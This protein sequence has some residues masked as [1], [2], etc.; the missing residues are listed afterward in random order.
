MVEQAFNY[1]SRLKSSFISK[2]SIKTTINSEKLIIKNNNFGNVFKEKDP[3][4]IIGLKKYLKTPFS[5]KD[6]ST[7]ENIENLN[8]WMENI[9][10]SSERQK[11]SFSKEE[12]QV[13]AKES[14]KKNF[15]D[16]KEENKNVNNNIKQ[17][18]EKKLFENDSLSIINDDKKYIKN[19]KIDLLNK[20][21]MTKDVNISIQ[22]KFNII[23]EENKINNDVLFSQEK[24]IKSKKISNESY[25]KQ[26]LGTRYRDEDDEFISYAE[27]KFMK[28]IKEYDTEIKK[29][30]KMKLKFKK[31]FK[32][33]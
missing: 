8:N 13:I 32:K 11:Y 7:K 30:S 9:N 27:K 5:T 23:N 19:H 14:I 28:S 3:N 22:S 6:K 2:N 1:D 20:L 29:I 21:N 15:D 17:E 10:S 33:K 4:S 24:K 25:L 26:I 12:N 16:D 18:R 31:R